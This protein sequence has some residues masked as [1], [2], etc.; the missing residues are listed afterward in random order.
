MLLL[1]S[2]EYIPLHLMDKEAL[3]DACTIGG[4]VSERMSPLSSSWRTEMK[5]SH[6]PPGT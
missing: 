3:C 1:N 2:I 5:K 4:I 6:F